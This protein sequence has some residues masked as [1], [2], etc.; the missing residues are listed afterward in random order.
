MQDM[1]SCR[2][3]VTP[4]TYGKNDPRL[5]R[6]LEAAVGEVIYSKL[7]RP[8]TSLELRELLPGSMDISPVWTTSIEP[9]WRAR[10]ASR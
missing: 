10:T 7:G 1:K 6:K 3:L 8:L 5:R 9:P 4:T 2:V